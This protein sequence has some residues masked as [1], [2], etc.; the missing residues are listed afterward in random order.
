M[1][2]LVTKHFSCLKYVLSDSYHEEKMGVL[3]SFKRTKEL[4]KAS[5][6]SMYDENTRAISREHAWILSNVAVR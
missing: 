6:W 3:H 5:S 1:S 4:E 2:A